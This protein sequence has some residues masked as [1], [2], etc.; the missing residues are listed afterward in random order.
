MKRMI[1]LTL[2]LLLLLSVSPAQEGSVVSAPRFGGDQLTIPVKVW[3]EVVRPGIYEVPFE[4]DLLAVL[5][6]AGGPENT[7]KLTN[8]KVLRATR[9]NKDDPIVVYVD[10][11]QYIETGN[12]ELIPEIRM[13]DTIM[14]PPK[15]GKNFVRNFAAVLAIAQSIVIMA[16]YIDRVLE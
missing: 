11:Q 13:G 4:Y 7:A 1:S 2:V 8:V 10:L 12:E 9:I 15:F 14:V 3:G 6:V 5:S 16:Y